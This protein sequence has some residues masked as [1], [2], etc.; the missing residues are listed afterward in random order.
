M[1]CSVFQ[2]IK[3]ELSSA[4][5]GGSIGAERSVDILVPANDN[6]YGTF[7]FDQSIYSVQ[8]P[9]EGVQ[10]ANITVRRR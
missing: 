5:N 8:E 4:S 2:I 7:F 1:S 10:I 9:L 6:P 3:V